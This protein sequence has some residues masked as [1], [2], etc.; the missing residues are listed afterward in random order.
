MIAVEAQPVPLS[1][2]HSK[3]DDRKRP[4]NYDHE[5][6]APPLK[7][8][9]ISTANGGSRSHQDIEIPAYHELDVS[10]NS[11]IPISSSIINILTF[12]FPDRNSK[13]RLFT[14]A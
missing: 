12:D 8:Q 4:A 5:E 11:S 13:K 1:S 3:M 14:V 7:R 2:N 6:I 9:A 10:L